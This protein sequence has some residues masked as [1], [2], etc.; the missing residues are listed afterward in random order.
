MEFPVAAPLVGALPPDD[1]LIS[2]HPA[3]LTL[4]SWIPD[5]SA[6]PPIPGR[7]SKAGDGEEEMWLRPNVLTVAVGLAPPRRM[8]RERIN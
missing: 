8:P 3:A 2:T 1:A 7:R 6:D 4:S 5:I